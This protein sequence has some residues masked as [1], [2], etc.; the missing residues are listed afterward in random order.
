[1]PAI[2]LDRD[3]SA[4]KIIAMT[5]VWLIGRFQCSESAP[6]AVEV[7]RLLPGASIRVFRNPED[8]LQTP[9]E[10][11]DLIVVLQERPHA[12][13]I[14]EIDRL[15]EAHPLARLVVALAD[16]C[17]SALRTEAVWPESATVPL[18]GLCSRLRREAA[19][20]RDSSEST[21][22]TSSREEVVL[23]ETTVCRL[24]AAPLPLLVDSPDRVFAELLRSVA[25]EVGATAITH[26]EGQQSYGVL[27]DADPAVGKRLAALSECRAQPGLCWIVALTAMPFVSEVGRL[28]RA[29]ADIV[30]P[31]PFDI[32][33]LALAL[34]GRPSLDGPD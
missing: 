14:R 5:T 10:A 16:W 26:A 18:W 29:G 21:L 15:V 7:M 20:L 31:K 34:A 1:M 12:F 3:R 27:W 28:R 6:V 13:L 32:E 8:A 24:Q 25:E 19:A 22:F 9:T 17:A 33:E 23:L 30:L 11:P 2:D 4:T